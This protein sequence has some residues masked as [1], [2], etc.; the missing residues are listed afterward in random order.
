MCDIASYL[1][2]YPCYKYA[3]SLKCI[4]LLSPKIPYYAIKKE[5]CDLAGHPYDTC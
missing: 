3:N 1:T 2:V 5:L 4:Q